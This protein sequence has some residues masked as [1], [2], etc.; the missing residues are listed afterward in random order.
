M[1]ADLTRSIVDV[2]DVST[3]TVAGYVKI[4][5][6]DTGDQVTDGDYYMP[7]YTLA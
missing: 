4:E 6:D 7:F 2:G 3:A 1:A 5:I